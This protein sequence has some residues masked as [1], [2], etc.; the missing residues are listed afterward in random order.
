MGAVHA[1]K[2]RSNSF[3][4][5]IKNIK[6]TIRPEIERTENDMDGSRVG[7]TK[8]SYCFA[9]FFLIFL[10][11]FRWVQTYQFNAQDEPN[12]KVDLFLQL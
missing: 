10:L 7:L 3:L 2:P 12:S 1:L 9:F 6:G 5:S 4:T 8:V 11:V